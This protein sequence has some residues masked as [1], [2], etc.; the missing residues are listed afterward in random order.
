MTTF[1]P[2]MTVQT[3][4]DRNVRFLFACSECAAL[5]DSDGRERHLSWH[6][7]Q[8]GELAPPVLSRREGDLVRAVRRLIEAYDSG[9]LPGWGGAYVADLTDA[10]AG[11]SPDEVQS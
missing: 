9:M 1:R 7:G 4:G 10:A 3:S 5:V 6:R 2:A 8:A 11:Y